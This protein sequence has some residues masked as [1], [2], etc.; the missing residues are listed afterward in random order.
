[1]SGLY[2]Y[3][4]IR[5]RP[6]AETGEFANIGV[7]VTHVSSGQTTFRLAAKRFGRVKHFFDGAYESYRRANGYIRKELER[8]VRDMPLLNDANDQ[9]FYENFSRERESSTIFSAPRIMKA[10]ESLQEVADILYDRYIG[11]NFEVTEN[12]EASLAKN[13]RENLRARGILHFKTL[14]LDDDVVP[15]ILPLAHRADEIYGIKPLAFPQKSPLSILDHGSNWKI[16]FNYLLDKGKLKPHNVLLA[17]A[18]PKNFDSSFHEAYEI[19]K[20]DLGNLPFNI[21]VADQ[22]P[23]SNDL[24]INF[25]SKTPFDSRIMVRH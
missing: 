3:S 17:L 11:R 5:F 4:I 18:P 6:F 10:T 24:L 15:I 19:V 14:R 2:R 13:I 12:V 8:A 7:L 1:M 23:S 25:A 22:S 9:F 16:R 21:V 20:S